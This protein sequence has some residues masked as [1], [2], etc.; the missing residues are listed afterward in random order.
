MK[1]HVN[2]ILAIKK[3]EKEPRATSSPLLSPY[4]TMLKQANSLH[5]LHTWCVSHPLIQSPHPFPRERARSGDKTAAS[6]ASFPG[7]FVVGPSEGERK[8]PEMY[9][10]TFLPITL[11]NE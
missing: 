3:E 1:K 9:R 6:I 5:S 10:N 7:E 8:R 11:Y 2:S 4:F